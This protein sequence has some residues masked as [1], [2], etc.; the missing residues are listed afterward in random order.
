MPPSVPSSL[1][2]VSAELGATGILIFR[3]LTKLKDKPLEDE[4]DDRRLVADYASD[5]IVFQLKKKVP[6]EKQKEFGLVSSSQFVSV[7]PM[8]KKPFLALVSS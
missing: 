5:R 4:G 1:T 2:L 8:L 3:D 6:T 7:C